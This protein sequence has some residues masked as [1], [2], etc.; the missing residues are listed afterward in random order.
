MPP[1]LHFH[2]AL[3]RAEFGLTAERPRNNRK[4]GHRPM[5]S[6][7]VADRSHPF[8]LYGLVERVRIESYCERGRRRGSSRSR[9]PSPM[10]LKDNTESAIIIPG[11]INR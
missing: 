3:E 8:H 10:K 1:S 7:G 4:T 9:N 6:K 5:C 11:K 2:P